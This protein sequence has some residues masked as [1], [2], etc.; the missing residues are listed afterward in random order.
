MSS[1]TPQDKDRLARRLGVDMTHPYAAALF[2]GVT[3]RYGPELVGML[4]Q[5]WFD[6]KP[7]SPATAVGY[8][9]K[10]ARFQ[11]FAKD[12][13]LCP[14]PASE[15][16]VLTYAQF[17]L[18]SGAKPSSIGRELDAIDWMHR[19]EDYP[20]PGQTPLL[21]KWKEGAA[22]E[23]QDPARQSFPLLP[24]HVRAIVLAVKRGAVDWPRCS[25]ERNMLRRL[26]AV[27]WFL[28]LFATGIRISDA[29]RLKAS[30]VVVDAGGWARVQV[31]RSK[32]HPEGVSYRLCPAADPRWCPVRAL[33]AWLEAATQAGG[34]P[35]GRLF[36]QVN[37]YADILSDPI[38]GLKGEPLWAKI[39][40]LRSVENEALREAANGAGINWNE[41]QYALSSRSF[42][43]GLA[44]A[45]HEA[46]AEVSH[47]QKSLGHR[48]HA[49]TARYVEGGSG[50]AEGSAV[51]VV[52][53]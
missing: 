18:E 11:R 21:K 25:R 36:A 48:L 29:I 47:I 7:V 15:D 43:R 6:T 20:Q 2:E 3:R 52:L 41:D 40:S 13:G 32:N 8:R 45:A 24:E 1:I 53:G 33:I 50:L 28:V 14:L 42:R 44:T 9:N 37:G 31:P 39:D 35:N 23:D 16:T 5:G 46:G 4:Q 12:F 26:R 34:L 22:N 27:A 19:N 30:W 17:R 10:Y 49:T 38:A 51:R